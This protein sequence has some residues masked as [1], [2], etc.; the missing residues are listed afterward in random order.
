[1][2]PG[3]T[4]RNR[5]SSCLNVVGLSTDADAV[6]QGPLGD[7][8]GL[9]RR[10][11]GDPAGRR[12]RIEQGRRAE[13]IH[14]GR[15]PGAPNTLDG[16][17]QRRRCGHRHA[18]LRRRADRHDAIAIGNPR[19]GHV[20][21]FS[22]RDVGQEALLHGVLVGD[23]GNRLLLGE[24]ADELV[25]QRRRL[26][27]RHFGGGPRIE[28]QEVQAL[29]VQLGL[30]EAEA[31]DALG[32]GEERR[33]TLGRRAVGD[34]R[35]QRRDLG[36]P[37]E[38]LATGPGGQ[39]RRV[40]PCG[41]LVESR[42]QHV[43]NHVVEDHPAV[44]PDRG[45]IAERHGAVDA[46]Q[47]ADRLG[48][49]DHRVARLGV[50]GHVEPRPGPRRDGRGNRREMRPD[51]RGHRL[52]V[53]VADRDHA[54]QIGAVPVPVEA[55]QLIGRRGS[56]DVGQ[57]NRQALG[58]ARAAQQ[59][60][61]L[62][63]LDAGVGA[64]AEAPLLQDDSPFLVHLVR[65]ER[66]V[67]R[68]VLKHEHRAV[69]HRRIVGRH[70][71]LVHRFVVAGV[72]VHVRAEAHADRLQERHDALARKVRG[73]VERHVLDEVRQPALVVVFEDRTRVDDEPELRPISRLRVDANVVT[74]S[75][76]QRPHG[77][78][79]IDRDLRGEVDRAGGRGR[80]RLA[81]RQ[82]ARRGPQ[83]QQAED[84]DTRGA[85]SRGV[86]LSHGQDLP[87]GAPA[88]RNVGGAT[89]III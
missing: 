64:E 60:R 7:A 16:R 54:H 75:V 65:V 38:Q 57:P 22:E 62:H 49:R 2:P 42:R 85:V 32:F 35:L 66:H 28:A 29:A 47:R 5:I 23:P 26:G 55:A 31:R 14:I 78:A 52:R 45:L 6:R 82:S 61:E 3:L 11:A 71:Q 13:R 67:L 43:A 51:E 21:D 86:R 9:A 24:V 10:R 41:D 37:H 44:R 36:R 15:E 70:L 56:N 34:A 79:G 48:I 73:A 27:R 68:P 19:L 30:G 72:R 74:Q 1:M 88:S 77:D 81:G 63:V 87:R 12:Q 58:I 69:E 84:E 46:H 59:H 4:A 25:G 33:H 89:P 17:G 53:E 83:R 8:D 20:I 40:G 39:E 76:G 50:L 80:A 18:R